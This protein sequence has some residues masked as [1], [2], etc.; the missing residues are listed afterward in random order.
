M[1]SGIGIA[2][3]QHG[4]KPAVGIDPVHRFAGG[5]IED[6]RAAAEPVD[7]GLRTAIR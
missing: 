1:I 5:E 6:M 4:G 2:S 7:T 3:L